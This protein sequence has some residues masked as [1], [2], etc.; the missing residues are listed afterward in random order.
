MYYVNTKTI[1]NLICNNKI[2]QLFQTD[3]LSTIIPTS[4]TNNIYPIR[5]KI[6]CCQYTMS[7][8]RLTTIAKT[9]TY[10]QLR[11]PIEVYLTVFYNICNQCNLIYHTSTLKTFLLLPNLRISQKHTLHHYLK[12]ERKSKN[13]SQS[14]ENSIFKKIYL[15]IQTIVPVS[16]LLSIFQIQLSINSNKKQ[17]VFSATIYPFIYLDIISRTYLYYKDF[18]H[19]RSIDQ[20]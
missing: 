13:Y 4:R 20:V 3:Y 1:S 12:L 8:P 17:L 10:Q 14:L 16:S 9:N 19:D 11:I 2:N 6:I 15:D 7:L 5:S 18:Q